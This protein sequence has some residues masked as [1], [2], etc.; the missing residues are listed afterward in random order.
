MSQEHDIHIKHAY[1]ICPKCNYEWQTQLDLLNDSTLYILG[2]QAALAEK[3]EGLILFNH[4]I[5]NDKCNTTLSLKV[6]DFQK[7]YNGPLFDEIK[8]K[9]DECSGFC[10]DIENLSQ[11]SAKCRNS[12]ARDIINKIIQN[13]AVKVAQKRF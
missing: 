3:D 6:S 8:H 9:S 1:K 5:E 13:Y 4:I 2:F 12:V 7:L 11:C 10:S